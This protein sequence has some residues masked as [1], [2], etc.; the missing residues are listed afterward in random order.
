M[1]PIAVPTFLHDG[2]AGGRGIPEGAKGFPALEGNGG[3]RRCPPR[4]E[5]S[6]LPCTEKDEFGSASQVQHQAIGKV[7]TYPCFV[8]FGDQIGFKP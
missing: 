2:T 6:V 5:D 1:S 3:R 8:S 7:E 4:T